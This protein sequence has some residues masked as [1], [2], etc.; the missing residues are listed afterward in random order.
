[1]NGLID[2][3]ATSRWYNMS[4]KDK[5]FI[6]IF[7]FFIVLFFMPLGHAFMILIQTILGETYQFVGAIVVGLLGFA[8]LLLS[9]KKE[10]ETIRTF[11]GLIAGILL[12][13]GFVEFSFVFFTKHL[14][15]A[16][17]IENGEIVTK[18]EYLLLPST[19]GLYLTFVI[20][21]FLDGQIHCNFFT[22]FRRLF[23]MHLPSVPD[24]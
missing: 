6:G 1:V 21:F 9:L 3:F 16:P 18:P 8:A 4:L 15:I 14:A 11:L 12:W 24:A 20:Y 19:L 17:V 22:W 10:S 23:K 2:G 13:T 7:A 5:P